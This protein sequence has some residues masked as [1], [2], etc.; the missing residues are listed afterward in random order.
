MAPSI[1]YTNLLILKEAEHDHILANTK[2]PRLMIEHVHAVV[3]MT[4]KAFAWH[5][6]D[7]R[8]ILVDT[9][10]HRLLG[11]DVGM[12]APMLTV[13]QVVHLQFAR[14]PRSGTTKQTR[15]NYQASG[16]KRMNSPAGGS[17]LSTRV[18]SNR[19]TRYTDGYKDPFICVSRTELVRHLSRHGEETSSS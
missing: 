11:M 14:V 16:A 2:H 7:T 10:H 15:S 9:N 13:H 12:S 8:N 4:C 3:V 17:V 18:M 19:S 5:E 6:S 1:E